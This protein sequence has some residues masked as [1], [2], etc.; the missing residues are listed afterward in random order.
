MVYH[1]ELCLLGGIRDGGWIKRACTLRR[2]PMQ[3][4]TSDEYVNL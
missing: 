4:W 1:L 2:K 3:V